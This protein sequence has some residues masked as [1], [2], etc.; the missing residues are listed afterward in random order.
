MATSRRKFLAGIGA[1]APMSGLSAATSSADAEGSSDS[2]RDY[3]TDLGVKPFINAIGPYSSLGGAEMWPEVL[4]AM[5]YAIRHKVRISDLHDAVGQRIAALLGSESAMVT[6]GATG[7]IILGTAACMTLGDPAR[8]EA[9]P[10]TSDMPNEVLILRSQRYLYDR[11]IRAHPAPYWL[12]SVLKKRFAYR[13]MRVRRMFFYLQNR[14][15]NLEI[16]VD[17]YIRIAKEHNIPI[18]CDAATTVPPVSSRQGDGAARIRSCLLFRRQGT[19]RPVQRRTV[20]R[21]N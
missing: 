6:S 17:D 8:M 7:A 18:F 13:S 21:Q 5:D 4:E 19:S 3:F 14:P 16:D 2:G 11:S 12:K 9:L 1:A 10:D 20:A 15:E